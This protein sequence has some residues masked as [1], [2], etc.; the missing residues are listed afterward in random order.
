V[1]SSFDPVNSS[2][3]AANRQLWFLCASARRWLKI[4]DLANWEKWN[5][6]SVEAQGNLLVH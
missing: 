4:P 2:I 1:T 6:L 5:T 3:A